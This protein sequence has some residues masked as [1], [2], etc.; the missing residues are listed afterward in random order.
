MEFSARLRMNSFKQKDQ[1]PSQILL[2]RSWF[3]SVN[4]IK[5]LINKVTPTDIPALQDTF[6]KNHFLT[7]K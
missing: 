7:H 2:V 4:L 6:C 1:T 5:V 3:L